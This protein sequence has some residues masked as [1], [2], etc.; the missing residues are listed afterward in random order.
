MRSA[1]LALLLVS[2]CSELALPSPPGRS[3]VPVTVEPLGDLTRAPSV[4]RLRVAGALGSAAL[5]DF[6]LFAGALSSYHL[7][8]IRARELPSTLLE[9]ELE[10]VT[11]SEPPD[12][13]VAPATALPSGV[14]SLTTPDQGL[15]AEVRVDATLLPWLAR[16]W[17]A[18]GERRGTGLQIY[19]GAGASDAVEGRVELAP[20]GLRAVVGLGLDSTGLFAD[21]C[22]RLEPE[23]ESEAAPSL[24]PLLVGDVAL[25]PLP[26]LVGPAA[27]SDVVCGEG[28]LRLGPACALVDDDRVTLSTYG[29][30]SLWAFAEPG[31]LM[32][33]V[34]S[35]SSFVVRGLEPETVTRFVGVAFDR[36]GT[37]FALDTEVVT[38]PPHAHVVINEV[39]AN[40]AGLERTSE[41]LE[42][43]NDGDTAVDLGGFTLSD[44]GGSSVL[45]PLILEPGAFAL[46][47]GSEFDPDPALD[48]LPAASTRV[49]RLPELGDG[50]LSNSG[51]PL[52]LRDGGGRL[53]SSFPG[54]AAK[55]AGVS[56]ARRVPDAL[57]T[58]LA[59]FAEHAAP[60]ASPGAANLLAEP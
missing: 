23:G 9:R 8:R 50:G 52:R 32:G 30:S 59:S 34:E 49:V 6:R 51:E 43:V 25:E 20:S 19:C 13:V 16:R 14:V 11:W 28:E 1:T 39:L 5:G 37:R 17:P 55:H 56:I 18:R 57:D 29:D 53:L 10:V 35:G 45:P 36:A 31:H 41:W 12:V 7:G 21:S 26:L 46:V 3:G 22:V 48:V 44:A 38:T 47:V 40:P 15:V 54:V 24:P 60:G 33:S 4:L 58:E 2:S 42:L 27:A